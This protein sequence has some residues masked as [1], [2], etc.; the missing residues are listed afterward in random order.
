MTVKEYK[1]KKEKRDDLRSLLRKAEIKRVAENVTKKEI[2]DIFQFNYNFYMNCIS[3]RN[4]PSAKMEEAL[5]FYLKLPTEKVYE[6]VFAHRSSDRYR[7]K[8]V[9]RDENGKEEF[10]EELDIDC[11]EY[12]EVFEEL[13]KNGVLKEPTYLYDEQD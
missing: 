8:T 12:K 13:E 3:D 7:G 5:R 2:C 6:M 9:K 4:V 10:H 1:S 11:D